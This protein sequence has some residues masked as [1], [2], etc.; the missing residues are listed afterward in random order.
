MSLAFLKTLDI[1]CFVAWRSLC[2]EL[3]CCLALDAWN[4]RECSKESACLRLIWVRPFVC[5]PAL[6]LPGSTPKCRPAFQDVG[7]KVALLAGG[8]GSNGLKN[9]PKVE[10]LWFM[11]LFFP[12]GRWVPS[13]DP[14]FIA[15]E[16]R[17]MTFGSCGC[18]SPVGGPLIGDTEHPLCAM[19]CSLSIRD[20]MQR[21]GFPGIKGKR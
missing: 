3:P 14:E 16:V 8:P 19:P 5:A 21:L 1:F 2:H 10:V 13:A 9:M 17:K 12:P 6:N 18:S 4:P 20:P 11:Q 7:V 15:G